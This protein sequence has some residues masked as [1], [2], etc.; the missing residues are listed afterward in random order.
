MKKLLLTCASI[1]SHLILFS[2]NVGIGTNDPAYPL[3][4][5]STLGDK[6]SLYGSTGNHYGFGI[7]GSL[8]Q[9][10]SDAPEAH[11]GF[12]YGSSSNF[13]ERMRIINSGGD[14]MQLNGRILL[15]NGTAPMDPAYGPGLWLYRAD[16][17]ALLGFMGTQNNQ[18]IGFYGGPAGWGFTYDANTSRVGI[19]NIHPSNT[20]SVT[21]IA[22][23]SDKLGVGT[24]TP[25]NKLD[26]RGSNSWDL[27]NTEG[28]MRVG[29]DNYRLK[30]GVAI[31]GGGAG[32]SGI[33]QS[34]GVGTLTM[35]ANNVN[36]MQLSGAGNFVDFTNIT[37]GIRINGNPGTN[38]QVLQSRGANA[39]PEWKNK[40][41]F[42]WLVAPNSMLSSLTGI[43]TFSLPISGMDNQSI[44]IPEPSRVMAYVSAKIYGPGGLSP[45]A[46][47]GIKIEV[48]ESA[49]NTVKLTL[50]AS[51]VAG[52]YDG[53]TI[54]KMDLIDLSPGFY[55]IRAYHYRQADIGSGDTVMNAAKLIMQVFPL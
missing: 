34:G 5:P 40:P 17:S 41:Y 39:N 50:S 9:M 3:S 35:G 14:G 31:S 43:G 24:S 44:F 26:V 52:S 10:F 38:G 20:L 19:N 6:I 29:N 42:I 28:D 18:N 46:S 27:V 25:V 12:G 36:L 22:N 2:Q 15:R 8:M 47:G 7:Q 30:V 1:I 4:F 49:T 51:G 13:T 45:F 16:N 32:A 33:M 23:I 55:Q 48:W 21:G 53:A 11:I 54:S 37:G